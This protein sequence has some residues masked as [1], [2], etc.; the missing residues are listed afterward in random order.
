MLLKRQ[1]ARD[2][3]HQLENACIQHLK[4]LSQKLSSLKKNI[5]GIS[6]KN[7]LDRGYAIVFHGDEVVRSIQKVK[8]NDKVRI[9]VADGSISATISRGSS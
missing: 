4:A 6:P 9:M 2:W 1:L 5:E 3:G 7:T 8:E